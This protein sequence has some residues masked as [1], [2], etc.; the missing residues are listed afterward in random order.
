MKGIIITQ[1]IKNQFEERIL[2]LKKK[3]NNLQE[4]FNMA[5]TIPSNSYNTKQKLKTINPEWEC[6]KIMFT[7]E[8][9]LREE[10]LRDAVIFN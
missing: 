10:I 2:F 5:N 7:N 9:F 1:K 6:Q 8:L 4:E 3:L